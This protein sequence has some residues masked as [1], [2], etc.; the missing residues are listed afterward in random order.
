MFSEG[1]MILQALR[2]AGISLSTANPRIRNVVKSGGP[3]LRIYLDHTGSVVGV[4]EISSEEFDNLWIIV[5]TSDGSFPV[6]RINKPL[7]IVDA[8]F[9]KS[10][11]KMK[12]QKK[13]MQL[14][15]IPNRYELREQK[16]TKW[17]WADARAKAKELKNE[18]A[19]NSGVLRELV[20]RFLKATE[21]PEQLLKVVDKKV[22]ERFRKGRC[23]EQLAQALRA[24][25]VKN[26]KGEKD[27][28]ITKI[29]LAFDVKARETIYK[30]H[31]RECANR[32][33][34]VQAKS[35]GKTKND[36][37]HKC[38]AYTGESGRLQSSAFPAVPLPVI[39]Q[40]GLSLV[41]MF[42]DAPCNIRYGLTDSAVVPIAELL[43][44]DVYNALVSITTKERKGKTWRGIAS[45]ERD[46]KKDLLIVYVYGQPNIPVEVGNIFGT[47]Q[48]S[49]IKQFEAD[50]GTVCNVLKGI[51]NTKPSSKLNLF[52]IR[53]VSKGQAQI[54]VSESFSVESFFQAVER[55]Q[56]A[57]KENLPV[58]E[59]MLPPKK[60]G[61]KPIIAS[62]P[63]PYPDEIVKILSRKYISS[64]LDYRDVKG[65]SFGKVLDFMLRKEGKW[66][67]AMQ[68]F[69]MLI[70]QAYEPLLIGLFGAKLSSEKE[71]F[72]AY[73]ANSRKDALRAISLLGLLL[74]ANNRNKESYMK[75]AAFKIGGFFALADILHKDYCVVVRNN[76]LPPSLIGNAMMPRA[77]DNPQLAFADLADRIRV[78]TGWAKTAQVPDDNEKKRIAVLEAKKTLRRYAPLATA[79]HE[80]GLPEQC[81]VAMKAEMLLGYLATPNMTN[82]ETDNSKQEVSK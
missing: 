6:V 59:V 37:S 70:L 42:S 17:P 14:E 35:N 4:D 78:Y 5:R 79:L 66:V 19:Q 9:L 33:L 25:K 46:E 51:I 62:P 76:S 65:I 13:M 41:S 60:K 49:V 38:C 47:D 50:A 48:D 21:N 3:C 55:W 40:K 30:V 24:G 77:Y 20:D 10:L 81:S 12:A 16:A 82:T 63:V 32:F 69:L 18:L 28:V 52:V 34:P 54:V 2:T 67:D 36:L 45:G 64:G 11:S 44:T 31:V 29:Q 26:G 58:I 1:F 8:G 15:Q 23:S 56:Q 73:S 61:D 68:K 39:G 57:V 43:A 7:Y 72:R 27:K 74:N 22:F 75:D 71:R 53:D 80:I